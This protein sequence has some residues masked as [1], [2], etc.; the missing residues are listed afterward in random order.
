VWPFLGMYVFQ[1]I[2]GA[3]ILMLHP[4]IDFLASGTQL[5]FAG[6]LIEFLLMFPLFRSLSNKLKL[7]DEHK[8]LFQE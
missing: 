5:I 8:E 2:A 4:R 3:L 7:F 1:F 6:T